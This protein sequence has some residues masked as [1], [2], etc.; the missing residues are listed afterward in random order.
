[1]FEGRSEWLFEWRRSTLFRAWLHL[2]SLSKLRYLRVPRG[3]E[4]VFQGLTNAAAFAPR[5]RIGCGSWHSVSFCCQSRYG[6]LEMRAT[7]LPTSL[8]D[9]CTAGALIPV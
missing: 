8:R 1:M 3:D 6:K 2:A 7:L 9:I 5:V 4:V